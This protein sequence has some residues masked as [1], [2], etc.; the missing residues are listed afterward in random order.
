MAER[1]GPQVFTIAAHRGFAE[2]LVA[3]LLQTHRDGQFG[4]ARTT[5]ILPSRRAARTVTEAF[6]RA[7]GEGLLLP[8]MAMAGDLDLD[9][10]LG[11][12][13]DPIGMGADIPPAAD[14]TRRWLRLAHY[15]RQVDPE[16]TPSLAA[17]LRRAGEVAATMDRLL[18]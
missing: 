10:A 13:L 1:R 14:P 4:L 18:V 17:A 9:E 5:L 11:P 2:A 8:R 12:L 16:R 6:V 7:A 3:Q 15:L